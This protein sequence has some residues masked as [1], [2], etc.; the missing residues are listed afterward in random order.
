MNLDGTSR[1]AP[2]PFRVCLASGG[3]LITHG[4]WLRSFRHDLDHHDLIIRNGRRGDIVP[5]ELSADQARLLVMLLPQL[6]GLEVEQV[7]D[8]GAEV[9]VL[10][11][12]RAEAAACHGCSTWSARVHDRYRRRLQD[13]A[14]GG[15]PVRVEL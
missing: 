8:L 2:R 12:T 4:M 10:A 13:V 15:R 9:A 14:C 7:T 5:L 3:D 1:P 11:R 6:D